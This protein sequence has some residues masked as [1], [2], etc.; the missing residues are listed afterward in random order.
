MNAALAS[1]L[2][3]VIATAVV[4]AVAIFIVGRKP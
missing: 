2:A 3:V 4:G 1:V